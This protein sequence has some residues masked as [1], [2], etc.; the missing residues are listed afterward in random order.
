MAHLVLAIQM[1]SDSITSFAIHYKKHSTQS[2]NMKNNNQIITI[3]FLT[4]VI[5]LLLI[6]LTALSFH[7][8]IFF[9]YV[10]FIGCVMSALVIVVTKFNL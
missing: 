8:P 3:A 5:S 10:G 1:I 6:L 2:N 4:F 9:F 7:L